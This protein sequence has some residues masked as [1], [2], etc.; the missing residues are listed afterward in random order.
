MCS[1]N[2]QLKDVISC[3]NEL[4]F[5]KTGS[6]KSD[7]LLFQAILPVVLTSTKVWDACVEP[8]FSLEK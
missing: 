4:F 5:G 3:D 6:Y 7:Q 8:E 2:K 1:E